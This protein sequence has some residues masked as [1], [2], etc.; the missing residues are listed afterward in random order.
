[1]RKLKKGYL[2][3]S[4]AC[5]C[6]ESAK[7]VSD[8][9]KTLV[10]LF[11]HMQVTSPY[12]HCCDCGVGQKPWEGKLRIGKRR[13]TAAAAEAI[14]LA[15]LV[16]SFGRAQRQTLKKLT[17]IRV[18]ESTVQRVT[19]DAGETLA[20]LQ[21]AK[22][23]FGPTAS[24]DWQL[25]AEGQTCGYASLD[26]VSVPQ[27]GP[28]GA[29]AEGRMAAV[30]LL[31]NPQSKHDEQLPRGY[32]EVRFLAGFYEFP[33]L[34][35]ELRRQAAQVGW[36]DLG[37]QLGISDAGNGLEDFLRAN[38]PLSNRM[39]DFY[40]ASEHVASLAQAVHPGDQPQAAAQAKTWC[41][42]L[43]HQGGTTLR[44]VFEQLD[45]TAWNADRLET[46]RVELQYFRNHEHKM[47]YPR[48]LAHGWQ[49][50]SGPVESSCKRVVTQ[51]LKGAGMRWSQRGSNAICH[52]HALLLSQANQWA[53]FWARKPPNFHLQ[54]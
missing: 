21:A 29:K 14:S 35:G 42:A 39:L 3:A 6:G 25:D 32:D 23:T 19:E 22:Q 8:R 30:A 46:H 11:G 31:Y 51:R 34:G 45:T 4:C 16:T 26:H 53:G 1:M 17:G 2:G 49:I 10:S 38:F 27:Q 15:G 18:S 44:Q 52:L 12:Y 24:W 47:D 48:Y 13:V 43:K 33:A 28:Q 40:H 41:H 9:P 54:N 5:N 20:E 7:Y 50:G 37:Q 36:D